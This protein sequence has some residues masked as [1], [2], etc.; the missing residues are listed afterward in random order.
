MAWPEMSRASS[1]EYRGYMV[2]LSEVANRPDFRE[3]ADALKRQIEIVES[4]RLSN[5]TLTFF[6]TVPILVAEQACL[7]APQENPTQREAACFTNI[8]P[9]GR[10]ST[11]YGS[12]WDG[13]KSQWTNQGPIALAVDAQLGIVA[14]R[15]T[16]LISSSRRLHDPV[17]LHEFLHA[18]QHN[19]LP[20]GAKNPAILA[21]YEKSERPVSQGRLTTLAVMASVFLY[22][23]DHDM[24]FP[25]HTFTRAAL[26]EKQPDYYLVWLFGFDPEVKLGTPLAALAQ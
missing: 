13:V 19:L 3:L 6:R 8:I 21:F 14:V 9:N 7:T 2:D 26:K 10:H 18:Y 20:K 12:L 5:R 24:A 16:T 23:I 4:L 25:D 1:E 11:K 15:P 17:I 22:G